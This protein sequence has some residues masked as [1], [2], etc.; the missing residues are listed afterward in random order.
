VLLFVLPPS[1]GITG[2][3]IIIVKFAGSGG[4]ARL[5]HPSN[6]PNNGFSSG[7]EISPRSWLEANEYSSCAASSSLAVTGLAWRWW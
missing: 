3:K 1:Q 4:S 2:G 7:I 6:G 5:N